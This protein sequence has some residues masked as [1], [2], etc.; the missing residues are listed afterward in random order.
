MF[1]IFLKEKVSFEKNNFLFFPLYE[2]DSFN[3]PGPGWKRNS[4]MVLVMTKEITLSSH[5]TVYHKSKVVWSQYKALELT[6][7]TRGK[8]SKPLYFQIFGS[9]RREKKF[10]LL[11]SIPKFFTVM[12]ITQYSDWNFFFFSRVFV[13]PI[14]TWSS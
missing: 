14:I 2:C 13:F 5:S 12:T 11:S 4:A 1:L 7:G 3:G 9:F 8:F 6:Y 10:L